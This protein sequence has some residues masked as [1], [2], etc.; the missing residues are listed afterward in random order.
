MRLTKWPLVL[1]TWLELGGNLLL[2]QYRLK[3]TETI[4]F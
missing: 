4:V 2:A 3:T 1:I